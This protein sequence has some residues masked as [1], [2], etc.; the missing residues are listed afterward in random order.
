MSRSRRVLFSA[1]TLAIALAGCKWTGF[2][3]P[4]NPP[5]VTKATDWIKT[6][7]QADGSFEVA[8]FPGF[9]TPDAVVALDE[10]GQTSGTWD[11]A[12]ALAAV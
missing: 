3:D 4:A 12:K 9:E 1:L 6:Q 11:A 10:R 8:G 7:Q 5:V 2:A